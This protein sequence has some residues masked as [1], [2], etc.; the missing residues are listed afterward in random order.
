MLSGKICRR[1][2][3]SHR[4]TAPASPN[5]NG[6]VE[7]FHGTFRPDFP[8]IAGPFTSV[9]EAQAAVDAWV[10]H[11]NAERPHQALDERVPVTPADRFA[12]VPAAQRD[13]VD[14]WLP[15]ALD[16]AGPPPAPGPRR[17]PQPASRWPPPA[18]AKTASRS[19]STG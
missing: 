12:P 1:N 18:R 16:S 13:L 11:Y 14:L 5:Q 15:P 17:R 19:S 8:G 10:A 2:G 3:I 7:R 9:A 6:K 4:L